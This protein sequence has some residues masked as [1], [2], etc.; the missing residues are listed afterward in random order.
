MDTTLNRPKT[1]TELRKF[2]I[3]VGIAF[4]ILGGIFLWRA[5]QTPAT[6]LGGIA[7]FLITFGVVYPPVLGPVER[8]W[9]ALARVLSKVTTP[10]FMGI[11]YFVVLGPVGLVRRTVGSHPLRHVAEGDS[12]WA[13]RSEAPKSDLT[14][15]F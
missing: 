5:H 6:V 11:V 7:G 1:R 13:N 4:G 9:M 12:Y 3:Q 10:I 2:G 14:R 15:Q 8:F